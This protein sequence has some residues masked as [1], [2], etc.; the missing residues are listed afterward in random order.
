MPSRPTPHTVTTPASKTLTAKTL[1]AAA[2]GVA[3][4]TAGPLARPA[5]A[6]TDPQ[7]DPQADMAAPPAAGADA[8]KADAKADVAQ[9]PKELQQD[10]EDY[11]HY[12]KIARYDL[13]AAKAQ[14]I[15]NATA[16]PRAVLQAFEDV[17][18]TRSADRNDLGEL[19]VNLVR[20]QNVDSD[21]MKQATAKI[22]DLLN[23]GRY[24]RREDPQFIEREIT[25]LG[26]GQF[27]Y[28]R[29]LEN[30]RNSGEI[31]VPLMLDDLQNPA[32]VA[33]HAPIRRALAD[34][35]LLA[36]NPLLAATEAK[37]NQ[38][39]TTVM[40]TLGEI[41]Y[42][43]AVPYLTRV[44]QSP[45]YPGPIKAAAG[46][47]LAK[48]SGGQG[49]TGASAAELFYRL[50][51]QFYKGTTAIK[52]DTRGPT[53]SIWHMDGNR[54]VRTEVPPAIFN[55]L[56]AM[57]EMEYSLKLG[58]NGKFD[59]DQP[60]ALWLAA[61]Y[62]REVDL[63]DG[64]TD[65]TRAANQPDANY[66][67][68]TS[69]AKY[70]YQA[71]NRAMTD[72]NSA[73]ALKII[74]SLQEIVGQAGLT[75]GAQGGANDPTPLV[76]AMEYPDRRVRF[77]SAFTL[78]AALPTKG[79]AGQN[80]VVPL[81][82]EALASSGKTSVLLV[83]S[84]LDKVNAL[85]EPLRKAGY[86]VQGGTSSRDAEAAAAQLPS[87][88]VMVLDS[89]LPAST[90]DSA[91]ALT[92]SNPK[93]RYSAKLVLT[94]T[95][96]SPFR[97]V[98]ETDPSFSTTTA[99]DAQGVAPA[100]DAARKKAGSLPMD[101]KTAT[102]YATRAGEFLRKLATDTGDVYDVTA[103]KAGLL[104]A[105]ND[106]RPEIVTLAAEVLGLVDADGVQPALLTRALDEKL[107]EDVRVNL[108][109][110]LAANAR[111]FGDKL[112]DDQ[113]QQVD[114]VVKTAKNLDL[115][116]AAASARGALNLPPDEAK[117]LILDQSRIASEK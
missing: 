110:G 53:A 60:L 54:L 6:Q 23:K 99:K 50:G 8:P 109:K 61:N 81:L 71:L 55:D 106:E 86:N 80:E 28:V 24:A 102:A 14:S 105:L 3:L 1:A 57:R 103:G 51:E 65:A 96:A 69:G 82:T 85:A 93:V 88:D 15:L 12:G 108:F 95:A 47:A 75:G 94:D 4:L 101:E 16:D 33:L 29:A 48:I 41:G 111:G 31:A 58:G 117:T 5:L 76:R 34:L 66:Y 79:F 40:L 11:W 19:N 7:A 42:D 22:A 27:A 21:P 89:A 92:D 98:A 70:L 77:E 35:G 104:T 74:G 43:A 107:G 20:W 90:V 114:E 59:T 63:P 52:A 113:A 36:I 13:A 84:S 62:K 45:D 32:K 100:I 115:R 73:V 46:Q 97:S 72:R 78:A 9:V 10:V 26:N 2:L 91:I 116:S 49:T 25:R 39:L 112:S 44:I 17:V 68:V 30:L 18:R 38:L 83:M 37:D 87:V 56:M 64:A 67:G